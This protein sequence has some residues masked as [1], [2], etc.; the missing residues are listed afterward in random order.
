[1][2]RNKIVVPIDFNRDM[3]SLLDYA[4]NVAKRSSAKLCCVHV[5]EDETKSEKFTIAYT[6]QR[7][8]IVELQLAKLINEALRDKSITYE[9]II[10]KGFFYQRIFDIAN[11]FSARIIIMD[12]IHANHCNQLSTFSNIP[13][14]SICKNNLQ[15]N[16]SILAPVNLDSPYNYKINRVI[17]IASTLGLNIN[18]FSIANKRGS[19]SELEHRSKI[20]DIKLLAE[21]KNIS[22]SVRFYN[23]QESIDSILE[24]WYTDRNSDLL[25]LTY[26]EEQEINDS[27]QQAYVLNDLHCAILHIPE[28]DSIGNKSNKQVTCYQ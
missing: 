9:I 3:E 11:D 23:N 4:A 2:N 14:I 16:E 15:F 10:T 24:D 21:S 22:C 6:H 19:A 8:R 12:R 20:E 13:V 27:D 28:I 18:I 26:E 17:D 5:L 25:A 1:M 7:R